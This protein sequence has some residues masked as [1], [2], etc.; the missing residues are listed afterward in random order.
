[1][2]ATRNYLVLFNA[3][4]AAGWL[5]V[6][7]EALAC[8]SAGKPPSSAWRRVGPSLRVVQ[9]LALMEVLHAVLKLV[10]SPVQSTALQVLSR[11]VVLWGYTNQSAAAQSDW[12]L[13]LL[14]ISWATVEVPRYSFYAANLFGMAPYWLL[15]LRY[16]LFAVLY[17]TGISGELLQIWSVLREKLAA[18]KKDVKDMLFIAVTLVAAAA[19]IPGSPFM[20]RHMLTQRHKALAS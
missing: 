14:V 5:H 17:P 4:S 15:W 8:Y 18:T 1:M 9:T 12:S 13:Y 3:A 11:L 16:S 20:Y 2:S 6:L 10:K 19:Y 7:K